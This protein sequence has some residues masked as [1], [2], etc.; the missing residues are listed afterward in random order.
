MKRRRSDAVSASVAVV[1]VL[2]AVAF[3]MLPSSGS[4]AHAAGM[5]GAAFE[6]AAKACAGVKGAAKR[7]RCEASLMPN[8]EPVT[9]MGIPDLGGGPKWNGRKQNLA[10]LTG[11]SG[12]AN[13]SFTLVAAT[14]RAV[15]GGGEQDVMTFNGTTPGPT[16]TVHQGDLVEVRL[17]NKDIARGV[18]IHWHGVDVPGAE[19]GVAGVTQDAVLPGKE[20]VYRFVV[21]DTGTYWYHSHQFSVDQVGK[22]LIGALVVL[23]RDETPA[24]SA[25]DLVAVM[26]TYG[27]TLTINGTD[28]PPPVTA[29]AGTTARVRFVNTDNGPVQVTASQSFRVVSIDGSDINAPTPL[30]NTHV[31]VPAGGRVDLEVDVGDA[32]VRI[33]TLVGPTMV[34]GPNADAGA[35]P[36]SAASAFD[37]LSYGSPVVTADVQRAMAKPQRSFNYTIGQREGYLD[38]KKGN[39]FTINGR[40]VPQ[41]PQFIVHPGDTV[42]WRMSNTSLVPHP[43]HLHGQH[44]LV[45]SRNGVPSTG[46]PWWVDSLE[47]NPGEKYVLRMIADNPGVWMFHCH[48]LPHAGSGLMTMLTYD[49]VRTPYV[50]GKAGPGLINHPE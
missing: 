37:A 13:E 39:W 23:P 11:P 22:G 27:P 14:G 44:W 26:H 21:P 34:I 32:N 20:F 36:L 12:A 38:G 25:R 30:N 33:G 29:A 6:A 46:S 5:H 7:V 42:E 19:D 9:T 1:A 8:G 40:I 15:I 43:M 31:L 3:V 4:G 45:V 48:N 24:P 17:Q 41:V 49:T 16:L 2:A 10:R 35:P 18:T 28:S 47:V 50:M